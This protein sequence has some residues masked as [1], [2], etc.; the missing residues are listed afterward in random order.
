MRILPRPQAGSDKNDVVKGVPVAKS[1]DA[2]SVLDESILKKDLAAATAPAA[3]VDSDLAKAMLAVDQPSA[4]AVFW[5]KLARPSDPPTAPTGAIAG[6]VKNSV[7]ENI[8]DYKVK[9]GFGGRVK[10]V[11]SFA[12]ESPSLLGAE[13]PLCMFILSVRSSRPDAAVSS[14]ARRRAAP[15][16]PS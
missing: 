2:E 13:V 1:D 15:R 3:E 9:V 10:A 8:V 11:L 12:S 7:M 14:L 5:S 6:T 4:N 16:T